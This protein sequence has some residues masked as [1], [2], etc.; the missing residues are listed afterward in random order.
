M[1]PRAMESTSARKLSIV[2]LRQAPT[3]ERRSIANCRGD[4]HA[5]VQH[6]REVHILGGFS[7]R[8]DSHEPSASLR[9]VS[10]GPFVDEWYAEAAHENDVTWFVP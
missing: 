6:L 5:L 9:T 8:N 3:F 7:R 4:A 10:Q 2:T 1:K